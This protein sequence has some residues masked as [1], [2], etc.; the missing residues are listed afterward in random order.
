M[1]DTTRV[2]CRACRS[3]FAGLCEHPTSGREWTEPTETCEHAIERP[4]EDERR[5]ASELLA[6]SG[7][8]D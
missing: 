7:W 5:E 4:T 3:W 6:N 1:T 2:S 8:E